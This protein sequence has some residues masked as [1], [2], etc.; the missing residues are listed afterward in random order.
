MSVHDQSLALIYEHAIRD[1]LARGD[2]LT[3]YLPILREFRD[4]GLPRT[5]ALDIL[6]ALRAEA[7]EAVEDRILEVMDLVS[8]YCAPQCRVWIE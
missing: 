5:D 6:Q 8:G 7:N 4:R 1:A 2:D 3:D